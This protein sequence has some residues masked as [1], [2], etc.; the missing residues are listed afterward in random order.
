MGWEIV[1]PTMWSSR[2]VAS[3]SV[4][5]LTQDRQISGWCRPHAQTKHARPYPDILWAMTALPSFLWTAILLPS[6]RS[7]LTGLVRIF[8][9]PSIKICISD[10]HASGASGFIARETVQF[11]NLTLTNQAFGRH[12]SSYPSLLTSCLIRLKRRR[13][14]RFQRYYGW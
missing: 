14:D 3:I 4:L 12:S 13:G 6:L 5:R 10:P 8:M 11:S 2:R 9:M 1:G 7:L